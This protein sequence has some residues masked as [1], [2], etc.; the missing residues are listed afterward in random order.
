MLDYVLRHFACP[1]LNMYEHPSTATVL[2]EFRTELMIT[3]NFFKPIWMV[4][5]KNTMSLQ[6]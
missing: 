5:I 4:S 3:S 1:F 6:K 2:Q